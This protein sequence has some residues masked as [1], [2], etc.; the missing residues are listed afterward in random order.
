MVLLTLSMVAALALALGLVRAAP[1]RLRMAHDND[2]SGPQKFHVRP[3]PRIGGLAVFA[4]VAI[5]ILWIQLRRPSDAPMHWT[6]LAC[7]L[8]TL[9]FG[10]WEDFT[11]S[12]S[13][14]RRLAATAASALLA[15]WLLGLMITRTHIPGVDWLITM[16]PFAIALTVLV[17][18][19]VANAVNIIDGF[20]GLASMC[21]MIMMA[22]IA[23]VAFQVDD[24]FILAAALMLI[25]A[26]FGFFLLNYPAGLIFLGDGGAYFL[27]FML[28]TLGIL[29]TESNPQVS[30]LFPLLLCGYPIFE[31]LFS[32]YRRKVVRGV[33]T[34][35]PDGIHLHTLI[36]RR[37]IRHVL[38]EH[39]THERRK[40]V[41][42]SM[43]SP[44]LWMLCLLT[45]I[46]A[47]LWWDSTTMLAVCIFA[48]MALYVSLYWSIVRFRTPRW[49]VI[50]RAAD[51]DRRHS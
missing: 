7:A 8:P 25:G 13:P 23:Y 44:Y 21:V 46:P 15:I 4:G 16:A 29:L 34:A 33:P 17:V 5:G 36:Y 38:G 51:S 26:T 18:T 22:G 50:S 45:V 10:L 12:I 14:R 3:V 39:H 35:A 47:V 11:K 6:L 27:G 30:P 42:N 9:M 40:T 37:V 20:N 1:L 41:R 19:G 49:L 43:T 24:G 28:A 31:T 2:L 32:I 48:F